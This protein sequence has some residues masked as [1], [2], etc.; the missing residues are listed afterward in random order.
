MN[1]DTLWEKVIECDGKNAAFSVAQTP[2]GG[3]IVVGRASIFENITD[4]FILK[5]NACG[6]KV[7]CTILRK[8]GQLAYAKK[9]LVQVDGSLLV[10]TLYM[11]GP[12]GDRI[13]IY[14]FN[15][16]GVLL[17]RNAYAT[18][19]NYP[20]I[21]SPQAR[22]MYYTNDG[23]LI[24]TGFCYYPDINNPNG[25]KGLR[26]MYIKVD[27][28]GNEEWML[29]FGY[30]LDVFGESSHFIEL[31]NGNFW[32]LGIRRNDPIPIKPMLMKQI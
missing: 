17:W 19:S 28:H 15:D 7:W 25:I 20:L 24:I 8:P 16:A 21:A 26:P 27:M 1:G 14:H 13:H 5:L 18:S 4:P 12:G 23:G 11:G 31:D 29:P 6:E 30:S 9:V 3:I 32:G 22:S 2:D 10:L